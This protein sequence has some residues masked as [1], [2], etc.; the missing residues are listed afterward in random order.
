[1]KYLVCNHK[2]NFTQPQ[3]AAYLE[4]LHNI[5]TSTTLIICPSSLYLPYF[6]GRPCHLGSQDVSAYEMGAHTGDL[7]AS[8]L[9]SLGVKYVLVGHSER[10]RYQHETNTIIQKKTKRLLGQGLQPILCIGETK[11]E[12]GQGLTHQVLLTQLQAVIEGMTGEEVSRVI[13]AYEPIWA[14]GS[15]VTPTVLQ[16]NQV[17]ST[18]RDYLERT[19]QTKNPILY[20]GSVSEENKDILQR[21]LLVDGFLLGG[22][23]LTP[24]KWKS[25]LEMK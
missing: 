1:M 4:E 16:I 12:R 15:G 3:I 18:L 20:G 9:S 21:D 22:L 2:M 14:I 7:A 8:Q 5:S 24:S 13:I 11:E 17:I 19:Y 10:R 6:V 23:S 25:L